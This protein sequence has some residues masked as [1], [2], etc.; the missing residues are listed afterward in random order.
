MI[1][2]LVFTVAAT[3][4]LLGTLFPLVMDALS[5]GKYSVGPPYFNAVFVPLMA[6]LMPFMSIGPISRWRQDSPRR[7][8]HELLVPAIA[9]AALAPLL[10]MMLFDFNLWVALAVLLAGWVT[11]GVLRD[12]WRRLAVGGSGGLQWQRLSP[13]FL[14][15][16]FAHIGFAAVVLGAV[17]VTQHSEEQDLRMT[18]GQSAELGGYRF[19]MTHISQEPGANY[20]ADQATFVVSYDDKIIATLVP[21][22][23]RYLASGQVMTEAAIDAGILRDLYIALGEPIGERAWAVRLQYKPMVRWLWIG[24][25]LIGFGALLTSLDRRYRVQVVSGQ[26]PSPVK[27]QG[28]GFAR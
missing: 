5:L 17:V 27:G 1:N 2:N 25:F 23:R 13:S 10:S 19:E 6:L 18:E 11:L 8:L 12:V 20:V 14:G 21:E 4:V 22:K 9:M 24:A 16:T 15:M 7:W 3:I 26:E 28:L